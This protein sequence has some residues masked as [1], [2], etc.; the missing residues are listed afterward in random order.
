MNR[1]DE[2]PSGHGNERDI[3]DKVEAEIVVKGRIDCGGGVCPKKGI[4]VRWRTHDY[5]SGDVT[6]GTRPV[7]DEERLA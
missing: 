5:L 7:L 6:S 3:A 2:G 4:T 1:H